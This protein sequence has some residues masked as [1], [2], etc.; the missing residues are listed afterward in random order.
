M[1]PMKMAA[2]IR[3]GSNAAKIFDGLEKVTATLS[4]VRSFVTSLL[5][6]VVGPLVV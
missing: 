2:K 3:Y 1:K 6:T 4:V 5:M